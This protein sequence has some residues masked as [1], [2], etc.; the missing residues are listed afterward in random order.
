MKRIVAIM[1][2]ITSAAAVAVGQEYRFEV[3]PAIGMS[4]YL[5]DVN[6]SNL[7]K[8]PGVAGG[9][10]FR[11][12][13]NS[14]W[15]VKGNLLYEGLSGKST[16]M[17]N[18]F[19]LGEEYSFK[20]KV[21]DL[22]AQ[23]EFNF[24]RYGIGPTYKK[25]KRVSPY[26]TVGIGAAMSWCNGTHVSFVLPMGAGVKFKLKERLNLGFEFTMRKVFG[27]NV[28]G[29]SDLM[30]IEHSFAKNTDWYSAAVFSIT[31]E[32]SKRCTKC[33]YVE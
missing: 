33:H 32:F 9:V 22:G 27:D 10:L 28:D 31:Y 26:M 25:Y 18:V 12:I 1:M 19:P 7:F 3:G 29:L 16:D 13:A 4:G 8:H 20:S 15:A 30:G 24:L 14:R 2:I 17:K 6:R 23:V 5:G 11:Y 21:V